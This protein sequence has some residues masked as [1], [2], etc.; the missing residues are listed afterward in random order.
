MNTNAFKDMLKNK[1]YKL[2]TQRRGILDI[3]IDNSGNHLSTEEIY[4]FVKV[5][6]PEI[7]LATV[8]RTLQLFEEMELVDRLNFDDGCSRYELRSPD[9]LHHHHHLLCQSCNKVFEVD[10]DLLSEVE[11]DIEKKYNFKVLDHNVMFYGKCQKC[12]E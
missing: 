2:T 4:D 10:N 12:R 5:P 1:G 3:L 8:Y 9:Q 11:K 6:Y 7:G